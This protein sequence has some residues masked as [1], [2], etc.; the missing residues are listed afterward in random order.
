[1]SFPRYLLIVLLAVGPAAAQAVEFDD[2]V[3]APRAASSAEL[4]AKFD[5]VTARA[6]GPDAASALDGV[7]DGTLARERCDA[8]WML[9]VMVDAR[10]PLPEFEAM[11]FKPNGDGSYTFK[12]QDH[13]A[14]R[15]LTDDLL[16]LADPVVLSKLEGMFLARGLRPEDYAALRDYV[17]AHDLKRARAEDQLALLISTSKM[18]KKMQKLKRLD[19]NFMASYFYQKQCAAGESDRRWAL[20]LLEALE[21]RAQ[22]VLQSYFSEIAGEGYIAPTSTA[23]AY[24]YEKEL[25]LRPDLEQFARTAFEEGRL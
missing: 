22:R 11:G 6:N 20:G 8:R 17:T 2:K 15:S 24:K 25:L 21:P 5:A 12:N 9:G 7:R 19:D 4:K 10:A 23:D 18:A 13:P 16:L 14:W 1:M 3:K